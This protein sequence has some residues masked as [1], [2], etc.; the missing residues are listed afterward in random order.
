ML[1]L[2]LRPQTSDLGFVFGGLGLGL[3]LGGSLGLVGQLFFSTC[4]T[5]SNYCFLLR[6]LPHKNNNTKHNNDIKTLYL[7][8]LALNLSTLS[9][10]CLLW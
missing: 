9:S 7:I 3:G 2:V 8:L 6:E 10:Q 4:L 5:L 1:G